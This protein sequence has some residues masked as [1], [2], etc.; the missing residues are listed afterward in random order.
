MK[1]LCV[2]MMKTGLTSLAREMLDQGLRVRT[3]ERALLLA[4]ARGDVGR[5][6]AVYETADAFVDW[7]HPYMYR[8]F[9]RRYGDDARVI[10]SVREEASWYASLLRHNEM[11]H[12]ITH[13]HRLM[14][15]R[16]YP[17]GFEDEHRAIFRAHNQAV[18]DHF[19]A[20]GRSDQ[21]CNLDVSKPE[22]YV[23]FCAF[24]G[25]TPRG[26]TFPRENVSAARRPRN[27]FYRFRKAY[28]ARVQPI[29]ARHMPRLRPTPGPILE[30]AE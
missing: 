12:P 21:L 29:Y 28:N 19:A 22:D 24:L 26:E 23:R 10:L 7:P 2:G 3:K 15:G 14:F 25:L 27:A 13:T 18:I 5:L 6:M 11:A 9:L 1:I 8:P 16:F 30:A 4:Y 17:T 20:E